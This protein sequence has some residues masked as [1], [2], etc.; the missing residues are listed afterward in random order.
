MLKVCKVL[1]IKSS[2]SLQKDRIDSELQKSV[3][4]FFFLHVFAHMF[5]RSIFVF[6]IIIKHT[7][8]QKNN[9]QNLSLGDSCA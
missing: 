8:L 1:K 7:Y 4:V 6:I 9:L 3:V 5:C 2:Y